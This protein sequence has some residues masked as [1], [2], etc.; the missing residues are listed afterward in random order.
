MKTLTR[1]V[2]SSIIKT[3][4][5]A[6]ICF[7]LILSGVELFQKMDQ[8]VAGGVGFIDVFRY[9]LLCIP[10]YFLLVLSISFLF[11]STYFQSTLSANNERIALLNAGMSKW[12]LFRIILTLAAFLTLIGFIINESLIKQL[13]VEKTRLSVELFGT[14][15]TSD[16][17]NIVIKDENGY[18]VYTPRFIESEER[19]ISPLV[20]KENN[21]EIVLRLSSTDGIYN[22]EYWVFNDCIIYK[23]GDDG[24]FN[25]E[26]RVQYEL[27]DLRIESDYFKGTN[28]NIETMSMMRA[29]EYLKTLK[30]TQREVWQEKSTDY[31]R[32]LFEPLSILILLAISA[33]F[34]INVKK[35][36]LLFS[37]IESL[38]VAVVYYCSDMVF[39]IFS[40]QG[41][42]HPAFS[43]ILPLLVTIL[44]A[45]LINELGKRV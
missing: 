40:H 7:S 43:V 20:V 25:V 8:I 44:I 1:Y 6:T 39:S 32:R 30:R 5:I 3:G 35:N 41:A 27:E 11:A 28:I 23:K 10:E 37:V 26:R 2:L 22:G 19:I 4:I 16:S 45:A 21:G 17:R 13:E 18:C 24:T 38:S 34:D 33:F 42:F 15:S 36:V 29:F 14:D 31:L 12:C 9:C